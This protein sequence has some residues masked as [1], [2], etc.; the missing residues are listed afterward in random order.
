MALQDFKCP[1]CGG[2]VQFDPTA[3]SMK[4]PF[5]DTVLDVAAMSAQLENAQTQYGAPQMNPDG[6][7]VMGQDSMNWNQTGGKQSWLP[8]EQEGMRV[9]VCK[10]CGGEIVA[11]ETTG[12]TACPYCNNPVVML[13]Q[14]SGYLRPDYVIPFKLDKKA[15]EDALKKHIAKKKL[16]PKAFKSDSVISTVK[17]MYVPFWLYDATAD[18]QGSFTAT[19]T[20]SWSDSRYNYT[21]TSYFDV[22]RSCRLSFA[23]VP[24][25]GS[26]KMDDA[27]MESI[28]P[29]NFAD[30]VSFQTAYMSG[31]LADKYDVD[32]MLSAPRANE[33]VKSSVT[34]AMRSTVSGYDSV[35]PKQTNMQLLNSQTKYA[36]YPVWVMSVKYQ[37]KDWIFAVNGQTGKVTGDMPVDKGALNLQAFIRWLY[38][39]AGFAAAL[40]LLQI[41]GN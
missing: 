18:A 23:N 5:C 31:F 4:C 41:L 20:R 8:G 7:F 27:L 12:A 10:S 11:E 21:E 13:E 35:V 36:L 3:G 30:A 17:G 29:Y 37:G 28:E 38:L 32:S 22:Y 25:D 16:V 1:N 14:F 2:A 33:R 34:E 40:V 6:S 19:K 24:V 26:K 15:A 39:T 9:Y